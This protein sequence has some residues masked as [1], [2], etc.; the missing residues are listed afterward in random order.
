[1]L[2]D[3]LVSTVRVKILR[4]FFTAG[5]A[6]FYHVREITRR[7]G[8]EINAVRRELTR[9]TR[10]GILKKE[11]RG[12]RLYYRLRQANPYFSNL[13]DLVNKDS[14]LSKAIIENLDRLGLIK[15]V[16]LSKAYLWG[17]RAAANQ[18]DLLLV[19][20]INLEVLAKIIKEE[21]AAHSREVN[22]TVLTEDEFEFRKK[23]QDPFLLN[24]LL[25]PRILVFGDEKRY[26][27]VRI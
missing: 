14:G 13:Y 20:K 16:I 10:A 11:P 15:L 5:A 8:T 26:G 3:L 12:N 22:Y 2:N 1:M 23:R 7:V 6:E 4:L 21:E 17:R 9:L 25:E 19:G 18:V 27:Q 24:I